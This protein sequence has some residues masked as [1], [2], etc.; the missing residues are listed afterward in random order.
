MSDSASRPPDEPIPAGVAAVADAAAIGAPDD[1]VEWFAGLLEPLAGL[2]IGRG[3][4]LQVLVDSLKLALVRAAVAASNQA[5]T[6]AISDS[7]VSVM[8]GVHR[9]DLRRLRAQG[10]SALGHGHSVASE[11]FARWQSDPRWRTRRGGPRVLP[12]QSDDAETL[13]FD[14][15]VASVTRDVHP[16]TVLDELVR[17]GLVEVLPGTQ[18]RP[19]VRVIGDHYVPSADRAQVLAIARDNLA[20]H[21]AAV[22]GNLEGGGRQFLEQ[23][24]FSD[25]LSA[26][27]AAQFN[28]ETREIWERVFAQ[29]MPRLQ[30]L[31]DADQLAQGPRDH[32]V[33]LGMYSYAGPEPSIEH[34]PYRQEAGSR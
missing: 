24:I 2:A 4:G 29:A 3:V 34:D 9:K 16:R 12:R 6:A 25:E 23:S 33:R 30:A 21:V 19:R 17:L 28:R 15:L 8:T 10:A 18:G 1:P 14:A 20:D 22:A 26:Q 31:Y 5:G 27:A 13:S 11:V 7:R 32:R